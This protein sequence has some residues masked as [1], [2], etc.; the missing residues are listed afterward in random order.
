MSDSIKKWEEILQAEADKLDQELESR[1][2]AIAQN[3]NNGEHYS[4]SSTSGSTR[5][6]DST[7]STP[8]R[9]FDAELSVKSTPSI[10]KKVDEK[11]KII[12]SSM[13]SLLEYKNKKYGNSALEP[14]NLFKGKCKVGQRIDDKLARV[15]NGGELQKND[16]SDIIG[17]L[18]LTC[19]EMGWENF[20]EFKD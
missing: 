6:F 19:V 5:T 1:Q 2:R 4:V 14:L 8:H 20:D 9:F 18:I 15:K 3:G 16:V 7:G 13:A 12:S 17:Y 11:F 10:S